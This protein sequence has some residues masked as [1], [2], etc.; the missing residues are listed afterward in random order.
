MRS[1]HKITIGA[2]LIASLSSHTRSQS[3]TKQVIGLTHS[4]VYLNQQSMDKS[5]CGSSFC[6]V[7]NFEKRVPT[8]RN[9]DNFSNPASW[10][11]TAAGG[12]AHDGRHGGEWISNGHTLALYDRE[13]CSYIIQPINLHAA[14]SPIPLPIPRPGAR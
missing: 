11:G 7:T 14:N 12:T 3:Q 2:A 10:T 6:S 5:T 9:G 8:F 4:A 13:T 1:F